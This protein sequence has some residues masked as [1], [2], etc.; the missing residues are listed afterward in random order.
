MQKHQDS[1]QYED[2]QEALISNTL[3]SYSGAGNHFQF[4]SSKNRPEASYITKGMF[5]LFVC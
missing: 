1:G 3:C 4:G 5:V 2:L